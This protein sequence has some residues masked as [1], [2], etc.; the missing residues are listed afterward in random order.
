MSVPDHV[1]KLCGEVD[2]L[3]TVLGGNSPVQCCGEKSRKLVP[4]R[5]GRLTTAGNTHGVPSWTGIAST[6][7]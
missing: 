7:T 4:S 2:L 5:P 1:D 6:I 3:S